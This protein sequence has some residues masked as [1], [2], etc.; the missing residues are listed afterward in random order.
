VLARIQANV[1]NMDASGRQSMANFD[2]GTG[3]AIVSYENELLLRRKQGREIPYV[4]PPATF[5][6]ES[7]VALVEPNVDRLVTLTTGG[8][9]PLM[10]RRGEWSLRGGY[11]RPTSQRWTRGRSWEAPRL[12]R[13]FS[14]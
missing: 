5:L 12:P 10:V 2:R 1:I 11:C 6:I 7:P 3:D 8:P 4:V 13:T 14:G 9:A